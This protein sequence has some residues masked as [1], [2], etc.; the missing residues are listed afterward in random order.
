ML[1]HDKFVL[2]SKDAPALQVSEM[3][4]EQANVRTFVYKRVDD[5]EI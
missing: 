1:G 4:I 2:S 5:Q 3:S